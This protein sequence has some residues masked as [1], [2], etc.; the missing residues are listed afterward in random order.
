[1]HIRLLFLNILFLLLIKGKKFIKTDNASK[2]M[3]V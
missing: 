1:M 2:T 3:R